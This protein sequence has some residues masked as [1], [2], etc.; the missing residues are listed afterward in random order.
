MLTYGLRADNF[1][2]E[3]KLLHINIEHGNITNIL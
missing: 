3:N 2:E 1:S